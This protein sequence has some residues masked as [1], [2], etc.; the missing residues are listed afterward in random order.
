MEKVTAKVR[1]LG[2]DH[3]LRA[4][5]NDLKSAE[6]VK[7]Q[8]EKAYKAAVDR[9]A[10]ADAQLQRAKEALEEYESARNNEA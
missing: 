5:R 4:R 6:F 3:T 9:L 7:A 2:G 10:Q 8:A 1:R